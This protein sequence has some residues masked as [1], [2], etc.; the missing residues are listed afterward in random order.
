MTAVPV[1][2]RAALV[3]AAAPPPI[4]GVLVG[5]VGV[6]VAPLEP[7]GASGDLLGTVIGTPLTVLEEL[8]IGGFKPLL[9]KPEVDLGAV[10]GPPS[11]FE[12]RPV[13][14]AAAKAV[15]ICKLV[16]I[17][18]RAK[19]KDN[20]DFCALHE[21]T[22]AR[23]GGALMAPYLRLKAVRMTYVGEDNRS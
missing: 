5:V 1:M 4:V 12:E 22:D 14:S 19:I 20:L 16:E 8:N 6:S 11:P 10:N 9:D 15:G 2:P 21:G 13:L 7:K 18:K 23:T 3:I 17:K